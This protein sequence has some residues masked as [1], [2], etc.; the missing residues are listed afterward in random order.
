VWQ[1][2]GAPPTLTLAGPVGAEYSGEVVAAGEGEQGEQELHGHD[3][4]LAAAEPLHVEGV[5]E[6]RP[7]DLEG[8]GPGGE[9]E[10]RL[11]GVGHLAAAQD[12]RQA[13]EQAHGHALHRVQHVHQR[14]VREV[15]AAPAQ[16][17]RLL[18][19]RVIAICE[20]NLLPAT[21]PITSILSSWHYQLK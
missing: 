1:S 13:H 11:V 18:H 12:E 3:P 7:E 8:V 20:K 15:L 19:R 10:R 5:D 9:A 17:P 2:V 4:G 21:L 16:A 14:D 6:G